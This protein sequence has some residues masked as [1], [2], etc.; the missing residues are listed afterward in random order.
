MRLKLDLSLTTLTA[1]F[2][3]TGEAGGDG[4]FPGPVIAPTPKGERRD[5]VV[6]FNWR[7]PEQP[8][9]MPAFHL[10][11]GLMISARAAFLDLSIPWVHER[12]AAT[13]LRLLGVQDAR[14][15]CM[16]VSSFGTVHT[17]R[18]VGERD[19]WP[20]PYTA[21]WDKL[22][23]APVVGAYQND[24]VSAYR[25]K[26]SSIPRLELQPGATGD[27]ALGALLLA[28]DGRGERS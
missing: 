28:L 13:C 6:G 18:W 26:L 5:V 16:T 2:Q 1:L 20:L 24:L 12:I 14:A 27:E 11:S 10:H 22:G 3:P 4:Y 15:A 25:L 7:P 21:S 23:G 17:L 8:V 9:T 19:G